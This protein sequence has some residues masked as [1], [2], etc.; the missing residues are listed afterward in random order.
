MSVVE[1]VLMQ[2]GDLNRDGYVDLLMLVTI[3]G[4]TKP[5]YLQNDGQHHQKLVY[6]QNDLL[7][8]KMGGVLGV[9]SLTFFDFGED[10]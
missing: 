9:S 1:P 8:K 5:V 6:N 4:V 10:G 3:A 2:L 7:N